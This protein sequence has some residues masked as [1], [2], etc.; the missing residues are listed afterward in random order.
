LIPSSAGMQRATLSGSALTGLTRL[1]TD[2]PDYIDAG[3]PHNYREGPYQFVASR[4]GSVI[5]FS[6][7]RVY[8]DL[9]PIDAAFSTPSGGPLALGVH[10]TGN[11]RSTSQY[12]MSVAG[13]GRGCGSYVG[14][15]DVH[16]YRQG[17]GGKPY[18]ADISFTQRCAGS[19]ATM[20]GQLHWQAPLDLTPVRPPT[21]LNEHISATGVRT[22]TWRNPTLNF[23]GCL[24]RLSE[25]D[26]TN[27]A[28]MS[29]G[30]LLGLRRA[31]HVTLPTLRPGL[32]YQLEIY[33]IDSA[34][35]VR[36]TIHFQLR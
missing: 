32:S 12:G 16:S 5:A 9:T 20:T 1:S 19:S 6:P 31:A 34:G 11:L 2:G 10:H 8:R 29:S 3:K 21:N 14:T 22:V 30:Y 24:V 7:T 4:S 13:L 35:N 17:R 15:M 33:S 27:T 25:G 26:E 18:E 36:T 28:S 23:A